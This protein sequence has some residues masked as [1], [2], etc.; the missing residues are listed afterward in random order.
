M[1]IALLHSKRSARAR[2]LLECFAAGASQHGDECEL[3]EDLFKF[4]PANVDMGVFVCLPNFHHQGHR[5]FNAA[6]KSA[7]ERLRSQGKRA[8]VIDTGFVSNQYDFEALCKL[9]PSKHRFDTDAPETFPAVDTVIHY[10]LAF[11]GIKGYGDHCVSPRMPPD[12]WQE[13]K[14]ILQP[15]QK[16]GSKIL[17]LA[18]PLH[19]QSSQGHNVFDWYGQVFR[20]L[21]AR[22]HVA[23]PIVIRG[24]PRTENPGM[25][26]FVTQRKEIERRLARGQKIRWLNAPTLAATFSGVKFA[27]AFSTSAAVAAAIAGVPL[28]VGSDACMAAPVAARSVADALA[29]AAHGKQPDR[30]L[31]AYALAYAQ[32]TCAELRSGAAWAHY[33][34]HALLP[35]RGRYK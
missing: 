33:R 17:I 11:E 21:A 9:H 13:L 1:R 26:E 27:A 6:R 8:L 2:Y 24:H 5:S 20:Q 34:P 19:G 32:W 30:F 29:N 31:W 10:E 22:G 4:A 14:Q 12:R 28:L 15:W 23:A 25:V 16:N 3:V 18:Q 35:R 7:W